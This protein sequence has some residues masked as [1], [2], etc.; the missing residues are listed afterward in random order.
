MQEKFSPRSSISHHTCSL[1]IVKYSCHA[2]TRLRGARI[3]FQRWF[4]GYFCAKQR[5]HQEKRQQ[6]KV[7]LEVEKKDFVE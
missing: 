6:S 2:V 3:S 5:I 4:L 7:L 1:L